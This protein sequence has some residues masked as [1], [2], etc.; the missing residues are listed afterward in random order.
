[1]LTNSAS[2]VSNKTFTINVDKIIN[3]HPNLISCDPHVLIPNGIAP[4][5]N[6]GKK[7]PDESYLNTVKNN[8]LDPT[9]QSRVENEIKSGGY[10]KMAIQ[11]KMCF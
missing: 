5:F 4:K 2:V 3:A 6:I 11:I 8:K 1:L 7:L 10:L 9:A